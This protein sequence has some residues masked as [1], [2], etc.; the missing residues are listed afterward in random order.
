M[1]AVRRG[2]GDS[3]E[4]WTVARIMSPYELLGRMNPAHGTTAIGGHGLM[5]EAVGGLRGVVVAGILEDRYEGLGEPLSFTLHESKEIPY[6]PA[7]T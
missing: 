7:R 2:P 3:S 1:R 5:E 6:S 4:S